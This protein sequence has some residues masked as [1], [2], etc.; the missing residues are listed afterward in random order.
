MRMCLQYRDVIN[1]CVLK[2][3]DLNSNIVTQIIFILGKLIDVDRCI[4]EIKGM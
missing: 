2:N 4:G 3:I 1:I